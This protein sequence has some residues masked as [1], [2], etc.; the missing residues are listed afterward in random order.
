MATS[1]AHK[2]ST[3]STLDI[4]KAIATLQEHVLVAMIG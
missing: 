4:A 3:K 2:T 1:T